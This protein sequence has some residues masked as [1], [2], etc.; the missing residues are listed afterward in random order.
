MIQK[1]KIDYKKENNFLSFY[2]LDNNLILL[3]EDKTKS[4]YEESI[5]QKKN[6]FFQNYIDEEENEE[7]KIKENQ[8][9]I[10]NPNNSDNQQI[11]SK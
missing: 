11:E 3:G 2:D 6:E 8:N 7:N 10:T 1:K 4:K 5:K 9:N